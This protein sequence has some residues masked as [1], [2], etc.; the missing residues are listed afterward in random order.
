[1][2]LPIL[3]SLALFSAPTA[4][5]PSHGKDETVKILNT[6]QEANATGGLEVLYEMREATISD[7]AEFSLFPVNPPGTPEGGFYDI[8]IDFS[9]EKMEG[10]V[11]WTLK[12]N[13]G[14]GH[15]VFEEGTYDR[16]YLFFEKPIYSATV[17][18]SDNI[19]ARAS[20]PFYEET[21]T[22]D[23]FETGIE[24]PVLDKKVLKMFVG[25]K[26]NLTTLEQKIVVKVSRNKKEMMGDDSFDG[27]KP[28]LSDVIDKIIDKVLGL[29]G[30]D[31]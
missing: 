11:T 31:M 13:L 8:D 19:V 5:Q 3:A 1:M 12:D 7:G 4:A 21:V 23:F 27:E 17:E 15:I 24:V 14:A 2:K 28:S 9:S 30:M 29:F 25:P 10:T 26:T 18:S 16:Y 6:F 20:V 22:V